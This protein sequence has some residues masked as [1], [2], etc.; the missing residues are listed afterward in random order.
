MIK[1]QVGCLVTN[2]ILLLFELG[3][4]NICVHNFQREEINQKFKQYKVIAAEFCD[5]RNSLFKAH[6][7]TLPQRG[8]L[9]FFFCGKLHRGICPERIKK[10]IWL[11]LFW[12]TNEN[13]CYPLYDHV[14]QK[15]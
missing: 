9:H 11:K 15:R 5:L 8:L 3:T 7:T 10:L 12:V 13:Y 6:Y 1:I 14:S 2:A 4:R